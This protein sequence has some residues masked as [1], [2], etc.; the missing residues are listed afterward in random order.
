MLQAL[1]MGGT[2]WLWCWGAQGGCWGR[3]PPICATP[4]CTL[5]LPAGPSSR[6]LMSSPQNHL[7]SPHPGRFE[8]TNTPFWSPGCHHPLRPTQLQWRGRIWRRVFPWLCGGLRA[9]FD[10]PEL[11]GGCL[12]QGIT[13]LPPLPHNRNGEEATMWGQEQQR[14]LP[15]LNLGAAGWVFAL[16][17]HFPCSLTGSSCLKPPKGGRDEGLWGTIGRDGNSGSSYPRDIPSSAPL[18]AAIIQLQS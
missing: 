15:G 13:S 9:G 2:P 6:S 1:G 4:C 11:K 16:F 17:L 5:L 7:F 14:D 10:P 12:G 18:G 8:G 3:V